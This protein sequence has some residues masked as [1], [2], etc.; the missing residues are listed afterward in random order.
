MKRERQLEDMADR[1]TEK[2]IKSDRVIERKKERK[3]E[4]ERESVC[5]CALNFFL[6][7][8]SPI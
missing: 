3:K 8:I 7:S 2:H 4:R 6:S 5:V 1:H